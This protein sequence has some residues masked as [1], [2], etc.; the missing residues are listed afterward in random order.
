[1]NTFKRLNDTSVVV[2]GLVWTTNPEKAQRFFNTE[3]ETWA[4]NIKVDE[5]TYYPATYYKGSETPYKLM[6][7]KEE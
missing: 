3:L 4:L 6:K 1:M 2:D 5:Q 7:L